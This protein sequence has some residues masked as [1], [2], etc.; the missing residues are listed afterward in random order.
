MSF[1][2]DPFREMQRLQREMDSLFAQHFAPIDYYGSAGQPSAIEGGSNA[3]GNSGTV[4]NRDN[5]TLSTFN[6]GRRAWAPMMDVK[7]TDKEII[8]EAELP[9]LSKAD[10]KIEVDHNNVLKIHGE[11]KMEKKEDNEKWHRVERSWGS[12]QRSMRLPENA[13]AEQINAKYDNGVLH[14]N[15]PKREQALPRTKSITIQ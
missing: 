9:G 1:W 15:I 14:L 8:V 4:A 3:N 12:F 5:S 13:N 11:N 2:T 7:E 6:G 10:I